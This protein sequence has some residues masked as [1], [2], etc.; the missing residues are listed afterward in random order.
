[1]DKEKQSKKF[2]LSQKE[3][4]AGWPDWDVEGRR[5]QQSKPG[6]MPTWQRELQGEQTKNQPETR[7]HPDLLPGPGE[8]AACCTQRSGELT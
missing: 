5:W 3:A 8:E 2:R 4:K 1:M 7:R 6:T